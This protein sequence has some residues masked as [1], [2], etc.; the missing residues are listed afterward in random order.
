MGLN[1]DWCPSDV[2]EDG[3]SR[4]VRGQLPRTRP[5]PVKNSG[6]VVRMVDPVRR[7]EIRAKTMSP[8]A[9]ELPTMVSHAMKVLTIFDSSTA[10]VEKARD[11]WEMI[12]DHTGGFPDRSRLLGF[13]QKIK[14]REA[15]GWWNHSSIK[16]FRTLKNRFHIQF[17]C[18]TADELWELLETTKRE[19]GDPACDIPEAYEWLMF[20]YMH[21]P[22][23]DDDEFSDAE[24]TK[25]KESGSPASASVDE[26]ALQ[27]KTHMEQPT[28]WQQQLA[29]RQWQPP[30]SPRNRVPVVA[31]TPAS[32][33]AGGGL[34]QQPTAQPFR[35]IRMSDDSR[36]QDGVR[37]RLL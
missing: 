33:S 14:G 11:L 6:R 25:K 32:N 36:T 37:M 13:R 30:R 8:S 35:G 22:I 29:Q 3:S 10:T 19:R 16:S 1:R 23:E 17:P 21:R 2:R 31:A 12:E 15:E 4:V 5:V 34:S 9:Q 24:T 28:L 20:K 26:L 18:H 7:A 27:L